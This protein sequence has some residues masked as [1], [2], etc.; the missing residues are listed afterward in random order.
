M[1]YKKTANASMVNVLVLGAL[2]GLLNVMPGVLDPTTLLINVSQIVLGMT[3][4]S[5]TI[6]V[7]ATKQLELDANMIHHNE[8][9]LKYGELHIMI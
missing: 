5:A 3:G 8:A 9:T 4:L 6:I 1:Y 2:S 7:Q